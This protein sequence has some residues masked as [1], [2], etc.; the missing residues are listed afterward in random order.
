MFASPAIAGNILY[1]G[2]NEGKLFAL[3][4]AD[5]KQVWVFST[6]GSQKN[7]ATYTK[8]DGTPNYE[9]AFTG[10]FYDD[11]VTGVQSMLSVGAIMSS[12]VVVDDVVYF[13]STDGNVYAVN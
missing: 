5:Q 1:I 7:G 2:S 13:G 4:L 8:A 10:D 3:D 12:P 9:A 11:M 6:D